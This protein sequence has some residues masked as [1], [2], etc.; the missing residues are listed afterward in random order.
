MNGQRPVDFVCDLLVAEELGVSALLHIGIEENVRAMLSHPAQTGGS[1]GILVGDRPHP[2]GW[3]AFARY[4]AVY[5][6]ELGIV[7]W[8]EMVRRLT[9]QAAA[10]LGLPDRGLLRSGMAADIACLD[11]ASI[12]DTATYENPRSYPEGVPYVLVNGAI[13]IDG[14]RHTG[15]LPGRALRRGRRA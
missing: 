2:R 1:D 12:R 7:G 5:V 8:E 14:G 11:P 9:S 15:A 10:R 13:V 4:F 3:G 6:R